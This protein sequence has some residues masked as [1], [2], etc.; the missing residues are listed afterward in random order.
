MTYPVGVIALSRALFGEGSGP[1]HLDDIECVG[2]ESSLT[3]CPRLGTTPN[4][5]HSEDASI[6]CLSELCILFCISPV[7]YYPV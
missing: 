1:I 2:T 5:Q 4:C 6:I 3:E 7:A